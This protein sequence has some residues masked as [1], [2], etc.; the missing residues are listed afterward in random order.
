MSELDSKLQA[1]EKAQRDLY[2]FLGIT[3]READDAGDFHRAKY[4]AHSTGLYDIPTAYPEVLDYR[5]NEWRI[6]DSVI[7]RGQEEVQVLPLNILDWDSEHII[8]FHIYSIK[9]REGDGLIHVI[10]THSPKSHELEY[11]FP[12]EVARVEAGDYF[13]GDRCM[14]LLNP[15]IGH[16]DV[17]EYKDYF[18]PY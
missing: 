11:S 8:R 15:K 12:D 18:S 17:E 14:L 9:D 16:T 7:G 10:G 1:L 3:R 13:F 6:A 4:Y 5:K 2:D